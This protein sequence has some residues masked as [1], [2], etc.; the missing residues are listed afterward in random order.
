[1]ANACCVYDFTAFNYEKD[2]LVKILK[3]ECKGWVFQLEE[4]PTTKTL[5]FQGRMSLKLK[6][7]PKQC[8]VEWMEKYKIKVSATSNANKENDFY[9]TKLESRVG[10]PW[11]DKDVERYIPKQYRIDRLYPAQEYIGTYRFYPRCFINLLVCK[12]G[13]WGKSTIAHWTRL[14]KNGVVLPCVNDAKQLIESCC[15]ILM[16]KEL[17][18][19]VIIYMDLPRAMGKERLFGLYTAIEQIGSGYVFDMRNKYKEWDFDTPTVWVFTN[20]EPDRSLL[21]NDRWEIWDAE[22]DGDF[23]TIKNRKSGLRI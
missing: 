16:A 21:S 22:D 3:E 1:M 10:G 7:R 18:E 13:N 19:E 6:L 11:S 14:N 20:E 4:A 8:E 2:N 9:V 23:K 12:Q 15:D 5:H 17:R